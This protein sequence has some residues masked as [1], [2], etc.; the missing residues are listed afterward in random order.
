MHEIDELTSH[1]ADFEND[2]SFGCW[3][4]Y[5][6]VLI[7]MRRSAFTWLRTYDCWNLAVSNAFDALIT[8]SWERYLNRAI[9]LT[10]VDH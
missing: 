10:V 8:W 9:Q 1:V 5:T 7:I 2:Q 6:E 3:K 4:T